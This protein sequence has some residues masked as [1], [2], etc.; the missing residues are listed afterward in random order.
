MR[1]Y[2]DALCTAGKWPSFVMLIVKLSLPISILGQVWCLVALIPDLFP[3]SY[4]GC[5]T[6]FTCC[7]VVVSFPCLFFSHT[8][9]GHLSVNV[10]Y[11]VI[12][13][14]GFHASKLLRH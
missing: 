6:L 1:L 8:W 14:S 13:T 3:L 9:D 11:L 12:L 10:A 7:C 4:L 2:I 5:F